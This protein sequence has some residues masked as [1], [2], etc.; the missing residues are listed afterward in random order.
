MSR[1]LR[2]WKASAL[3]AAVF[4]AIGVSWLAVGLYDGESWFLYLWFGLAAL[5]GYFA[6]RDYRHEHGSAARR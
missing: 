3:F 6:W 1:W 2:S 4:L 5:H